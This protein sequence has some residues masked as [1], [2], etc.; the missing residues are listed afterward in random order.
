MPRSAV[1][2]RNL[3]NLACICQS[4]SVSALFC[5]ATDKHTRTT[6][7]EIL[8]SS[9]RQQRPNIPCLH[10]PLPLPSL[11]SLP[12]RSLRHAHVRSSRALHELQTTTTRQND[13]ATARLL[14]CAFDAYLQ[15]FPR[16]NPPKFLFR[17]ALTVII[18][19]PGVY[20]L[21][22][23]VT[24]SRKPIFLFYSLLQDVCGK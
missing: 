15:L 23:R 11:S 6:Y 21:G 5:L 17:V 12:Y 18:I 10:L 24:K 16:L 20:R 7:I 8:I 14:I 13:T 3:A 1:L 22:L 4:P 2:C 19:S 9:T